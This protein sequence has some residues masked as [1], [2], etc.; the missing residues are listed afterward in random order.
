MADK[1]DYYEVLG[2]ARSASEDEIKKAYRKVAKKYHPDLNPG[3]KTA[4]ANFKE[5]NEAYEVLSDSE[6]KGRYDQFGHAGTDPGYGGGSYGGGGGFSGFGDFSDIGDIFESMFGGGGG[7]GGRTRTANPNAPRPGEDLRASITITFM[8]AVKGC[9]KTL[10]LNLYETCSDCKGSGA[11]AGTSP[12]VCPDCGGSGQVRVQ[13]RTPFGVMQS[14][15][16]CSRC[17]GKGKI[18]EAPCTGCGGRG[19]V[20]AEKNIEINIP[21]GINNTQTLSI[22]GRGC[23]G[24][25]GGPAGDVNVYI[26]VKSDTVFERDGYNVHVEMPI[27]VTDAIL[28]AEITVPTVDGKVKYTIAEGTQNGTSFRLKGKGI[29]HL[30]SSKR[31]DQYVKVIVEV[32]KKLS[33]DQKKKIKELEKSLNISNYEKI[34]NFSSTDN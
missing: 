18:I 12:K 22:R 19:R 5:A 23:S 3:D 34:S 24:I 10:K 11:R 20:A 17:Q 15:Q 6:K 16:E 1:R 31:G 7:F 33:K 28:G 9:T 25:N 32:P 4:E 26:S 14:A 13:R 8:E 29:Q 2:V 27:S 21:A 30:N